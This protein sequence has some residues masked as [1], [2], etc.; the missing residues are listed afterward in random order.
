MSTTRGLGRNELSFSG[1]DRY[2]QAPTCAKCLCR[3]MPPAVV[4]SLC[5]GQNLCF[6]TAFFVA[7][8]SPARAQR[9][10][11]TRALLASSSMQLHSA[12]WSGFLRTTYLE[13]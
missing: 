12:Y 3:L 1:I 2:S 9:E 10:V 13:I 6:L 5:R 8:Y 4:P 11:D 7:C